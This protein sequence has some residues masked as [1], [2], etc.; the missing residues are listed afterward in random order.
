MNLFEDLFKNYE[1]LTPAQQRAAFYLASHSED[2]ALDS[3]YRTADKAGVDVTDLTGLAAEIGLTG[4][5]QILEQM[6]REARGRRSSVTDLSRR[7]YSDRAVGMMD[8]FQT[9]PKP[10]QLIEL[11]MKEESDNIIESVNTDRDGDRF[12]KAVKIILETV[13]SPDKRKQGQVAFLGRRSCYPTAYLMNYIY[14]MFSGNGV[15]VPNSAGEISEYL[16]WINTGDVL[17]ATSIHPYTSEVVQAV[18]YAYGKSTR[19]IAITDGDDSPIA[20][21][22]EVSLIVNVKSTSFWHSNIAM[23]AVGHALL[24]LLFCRG[25]EP[26]LERL[27]QSERHLAAYQ[28]YSNDPGPS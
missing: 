7:W 21:L 27:R 15:L 17:V 25:G 6:E 22:A 8:F 9:N 4:F 10:A 1:R 3:V 19:I 28:S 23:S 14:G 12:E 24:A 11:L 5:S 2:A 20:R 18:K 13:P 16:R 26:A